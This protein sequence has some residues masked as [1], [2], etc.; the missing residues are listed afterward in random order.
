M[1]IPTGHVFLLEGT[2]YGHKT[3][4]MALV[5]CLMAIGYALWQQAMVCGQRP[6]D[7]SN[8]Y[9]TWTCPML[10]GHARLP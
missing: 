7:M 1:L 10:L 9:G 4:S 8:G 6:Q 5:T 2:L 3:Y